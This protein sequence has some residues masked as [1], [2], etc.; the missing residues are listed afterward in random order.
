MQLSDPIIKVG[1]LDQSNL[2][3]IIAI[4]SVSIWKAIQDEE[5]HGFSLLLKELKEKVILWLKGS[6]KKVVYSMK[7]WKFVIGIISKDPTGEEEVPELVTNP[8][9]FKKIKKKCFALNSP[10]SSKPISLPPSISPT[11]F[12]TPTK[13]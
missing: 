1:V 11:P 5:T 9:Q 2:L 10:S 12:L 6:P 4:E 13:N 7:E 3:A 8:F